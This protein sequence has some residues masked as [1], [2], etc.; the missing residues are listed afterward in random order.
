MSVDT[1]IISTT[2]LREWIEGASASDS[3]PCQGSDSGPDK[4]PFAAVCRGYWSCGCDMT[5]CALHRDVI[6]A[7]P[8]AQG[9]DAF[10][11][12]NCLCMI[13]LVKMEPLR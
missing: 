11:C 9:A 10:M 13:K 6:L 12:G 8:E 1:D 2:E 7:G 5:Y 4:C 3:L